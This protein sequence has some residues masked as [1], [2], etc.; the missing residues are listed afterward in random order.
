MQCGSMCAMASLGYFSYAVCKKLLKDD[1]TKRFLKIFVEVAS[2]IAFVALICYSTYLLFG[3]VK[4]NDR[5]NDLLHFKN[6]L[7]DEE[8]EARIQEMSEFAKQKEAEGKIVYILDVMSAMYTVPQDKYFKNY[9]MF[10][11]GN[12]GKDGPKRYYKGYNR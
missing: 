2:R 11:M 6:I 4:N 5:Q 10:N 8:F 7:V 12:F 1:K 9:D 3:Y